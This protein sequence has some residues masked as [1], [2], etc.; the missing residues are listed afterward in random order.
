MKTTLTLIVEY[1]VDG[2]MPPM[3]QVVEDI[4]IAV[5]SSIHNGSVAFSRNDDDYLV[6]LRGTEIGPSGWIPCD[7]DNP[8]PATIP[9]GMLM[10]V[11][12]PER[13]MRNGLT[14]PETSFFVDTSDW[15]NDRFPTEGFTHYYL[16]VSKPERLAL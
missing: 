6:F 16:L 5:Q 3:E 12:M 13:K 4:V 10:A 7:A 2:E 9:D 14:V 15:N 1:E 8:P 11:W